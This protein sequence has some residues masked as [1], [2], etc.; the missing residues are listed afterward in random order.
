MIK[1]QETNFNKFVIINK[2]NDIEENQ[3]ALIKIF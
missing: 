1:T 2:I 3:G